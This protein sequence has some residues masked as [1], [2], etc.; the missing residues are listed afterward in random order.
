VGDGTLTG[1]VFSRYKDEYYN[2]VFN[3]QDSLQ[4]SYTQTDVSLEW[5]SGSGNWSVMAYGRNLEDEQPLNYMNFIS[6][7]P[8]ND[9]FN[10]VFGAPLTYGLKV[11]YTF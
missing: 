8:S 7:G 6:A 3:Y 11:S 1:S 5:L 9:D 2:S 4:D 10:W